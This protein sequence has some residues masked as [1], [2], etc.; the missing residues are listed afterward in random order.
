MSFLSVLCTY[1]NKVFFECF[2]VFLLNFLLKMA[3]VSLNNLDKRKKAPILVP[4]LGTSISTCGEM[5]ITTVFGT[6]IPGSSPGGWTYNTKSR[7]EGIVAF[8]F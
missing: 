1:G 5:D 8:V 3:F 2:M 6:V 7:Y 4:A